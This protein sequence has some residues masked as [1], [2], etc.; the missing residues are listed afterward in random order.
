MTPQ[1]LFEIYTNQHG[2]HN[3]ESYRGV[4]NL[5]I[6]IGDICGY[7]GNLDEFFADNSGAI[8]AVLNWILES[9]IPEWKQNLADMATID[10]DCNDENTDD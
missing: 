3:F 7:D 8:E 2:L 10:E 6:A 4:R 5:K 9:N 1:E